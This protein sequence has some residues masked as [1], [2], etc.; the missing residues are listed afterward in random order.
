VVRA[1]ER[2]RASAV[3]RNASRVLGLPVGTQVIQVRRTL[4]AGCHGDHPTA[5]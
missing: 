1:L 2:A 3:D 4:A 5:A